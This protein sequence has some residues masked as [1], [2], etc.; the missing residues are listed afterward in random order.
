[1]KGFPPNKSPRQSLIVSMSLRLNQTR[2]DYVSLD[3]FGKLE[4]TQI[5]QDVQSGLSPNEY[6]FVEFLIKEYDP[7][8]RA[9]EL[10][11]L[12]PKWVCADAWCVGHTGP[13]CDPTGRKFDLL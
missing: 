2:L 9:I 5:L 8:L 10:R 1:M 7:L 4:K 13:E 11:G 12:D 3:D 6:A